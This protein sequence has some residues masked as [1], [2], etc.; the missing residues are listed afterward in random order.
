MRHAAQ[1]PDASGGVVLLGG[2]R[3]GFARLVRCVLPFF[4]GGMGG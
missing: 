4:G 1:S 2:R 3:D